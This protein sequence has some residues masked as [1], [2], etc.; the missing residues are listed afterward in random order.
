MTTSS[1]TTTTTPLTASQLLVSVIAAVDAEP[2]ADW[3][4][5]QAPRFVTTD[6]GRA[7][8]AR[9]ITTLGF[10]GQAAAHLRVV[11]AGKKVYFLGNSVALADSLLLKP[12]IANQ[13]AGKWLV[14]SPS[15]R[16]EGFTSICTVSSL[17]RELAS[18]ATMGS[19]SLL[20]GTTVRSQSVVGIKATEDRQGTT[21][22]EIL[23][24]E[25][26]GAPLPVELGIGIGFSLS[27]SWF[28]GPW[29]RVPDAKAPKDAVPIVKSWYVQSQS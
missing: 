13:E 21:N 1:A 24:V 29:G 8:C 17:A 11:L 20:P 10:G 9:T 26:T 25:A 12:A 15:A 3:T 5:S 6:A 4:I 23:Y 27:S 22:T 14:A 18:V 28:F 16:F 2:A 19:L 7:D